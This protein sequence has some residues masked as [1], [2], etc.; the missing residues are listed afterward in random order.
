MGIGGPEGH[1]GL[2]FFVLWVIR[3]FISLAVLAGIPL[4]RICI[5]FMLRGFITSKIGAALWENAP[6]GRFLQYGQSSKFLLH[7]ARMA[8]KMTTDPQRPIR[9][10]RASPVLASTQ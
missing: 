4:V 2:P 8:E 6:Q 1:V 9:T 7:C 3:L 5:L 10:I